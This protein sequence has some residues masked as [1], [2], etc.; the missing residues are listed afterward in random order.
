LYGGEI[1]RKL[2]L[3]GFDL[4]FS[5]IDGQSAGRHIAYWLWNPLFE[6]IEVT[7]AARIVERVG[8]E[9]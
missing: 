4:N 2:S 3:A 8:H 6:P 1:Q 7:L 9:G 5:A